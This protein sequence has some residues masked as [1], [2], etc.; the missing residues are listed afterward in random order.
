MTVMP[1]PPV[2]CLPVNVVMI[3]AYFPAHGGGVEAV[4]EKLV[5]YAS[6]SGHATLIWFA[7]DAD[8]APTLRA[9]STAVGIRAYNQLE[10]AFGVPWPIWT[11]AAIRELWIAIGR[12]DIVHIQDTLYP[13]T[14]IGGMISLLKDK[15][16]M[17]T[18]HIGLVPYRNP[19]FRGLMIAANHTI[20]RFLLQRAAQVAFVSESVNRYFDAICR[21]QRKP[22]LVP[23][24]VDNSL[25]RPATVAEREAARTSLRPGGQR[26]I[27]LFVGR[28]VEKKG[29][30]LLRQL[31][32]DLPNVDW[33]FAGRGPLDPRAWR[34]GNVVVFNDRLKESLREL[35]WTADLLVLPSMGEGFPL[36]VQEAMACGIQA[37]VS[38]E[39]ADGFPLAAEVICVEKLGEGSRARW[40]NRIEE[41]LQSHRMPEALAGF[42][43]KHWSWSA[44][45]GYYSDLYSRLRNEHP[46]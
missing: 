8:A 34:L 14:L 28:F 9:G 45:G 17:V 21:W 35:Y 40:G 1:D 36:V 26:P 23:N 13:G 43:A 30:L 29:L 24:G 18:Q 6:Q 3:S 10:R 4:A 42:A 37:I 11:P 5:E 33:I 12:A 2:N 31:A 38:Q 22:A 41:I 39:V 46:G 27:C 32:A 15:P 25:Y 19:I 16:L 44:A 7:S 20:A